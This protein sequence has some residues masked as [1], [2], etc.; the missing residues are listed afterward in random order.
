M[1]RFNR[2]MIRSPDHPIQSLDSDAEAMTVAIDLA[3][4]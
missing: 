1:T 3:A 2:P 4:R